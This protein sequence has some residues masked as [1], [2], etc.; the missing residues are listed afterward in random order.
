MNK[1]LHTKI[2]QIITGYEDIAYPQ[3][4]A[5][6]FKDEELH[7]RVLDTT[8]DDIIGTTYTFIKEGLTK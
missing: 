7:D 4:K 6:G 8:V 2:K 3:F 5:T 1:D